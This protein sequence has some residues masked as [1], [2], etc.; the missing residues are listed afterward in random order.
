MIYFK[1]KFGAAFLAALLFVGASANHAASV[2]YDLNG[3]V[4]S[5]P[6]LGEIY[7]GQFTFDDVALTGSGEEFLPVRT[8]NFDFLGNTFNQSQGIVPPEVAFLDG[9][10]LGL[11]FNVSTF[12]PDFAVIPG[13]I[14][15]TESYFAYDNGDNGVGNAGLGSLVYTVSAVPEPEIVTM[16]LFGVALVGY[17]VRGRRKI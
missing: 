11:S 6:L 5:G 10:F 14:N 3:V 17:V 7:V 12:D 13:V 9:T 1:N 2:S 16:L 15:V 8:L 4:D